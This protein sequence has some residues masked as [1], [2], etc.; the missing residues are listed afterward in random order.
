VDVI[1]SPEPVSPTSIGEKDPIM[2]NMD[3]DPRLEDKNP[4]NT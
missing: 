1:P 3:L 4:T 2:D